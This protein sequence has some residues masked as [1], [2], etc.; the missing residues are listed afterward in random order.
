[1]F[2]FAILLGSRIVTKHYT[3]SYIV[4]SAAPLTYMH[5][6]CCHSKRVDCF[7]CKQELVRIY[8]QPTNMIFYERRVNLLKT[9]QT[10][11]CEF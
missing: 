2:I 4:M 11:A 1:M 3:G 5:G 10:V 9:V 6:V 7:S 8:V